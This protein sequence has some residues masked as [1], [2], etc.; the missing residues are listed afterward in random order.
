MKNL[1]KISLNTKNKRGSAT[2]PRNPKIIVRAAISYDAEFL[3]SP[4]NIILMCLIHLCVSC[5]I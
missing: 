4:P 1:K 3:Y 5:A 2:T